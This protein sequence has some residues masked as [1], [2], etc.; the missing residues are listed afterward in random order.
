MDELKMSKTLDA[1]MLGCSDG[2]SFPH[3]VKWPEIATGQTGIEM[4]A[5]LF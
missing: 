3:A 4:T 2:L 1:R 5:K